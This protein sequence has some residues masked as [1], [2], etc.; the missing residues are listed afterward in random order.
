MI[1]RAKKSCAKARAQGGNRVFSYVPLVPAPT[2]P[3]RDDSL[4]ALVE[5]SLRSGGLQLMYQPIVAMR[6][7]AGRRY[8]ALLRLRAPDGE[9][10]P[11]FDFLPIAHARG[12]MPGIDCWVME[13]ALDRLRYERRQRQRGLRFFVHQTMESAASDG[14]VAWL[15]D[16]IAER[17]LIKVRPLIQFQVQDVMDHRDLA[18]ERARELHRL[19]IR[20]CLIQFEEN[21]DA[22]VLIEEMP[23]SMVKLSMET[24]KKASTGELTNLVAGLHAQKT[25]VIAPGI[26]GP[27]I[28][29]H[30]WGCG[31]DFI[32][33]NFLQF[34][35]EDLGFD[36]SESALR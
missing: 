22:L 27:S 31:V 36:F 35:A 9:Y 3:D 8:E 28:I 7:L 33:G 19:G 10:I 32:Q 15:R 4:T 18:L 24:I 5:W 2:A 13:H 34:P 1:S 17:D 20:I 12:L 14:W 26:D 23:V 6:N 29:A 11:T 21:H 16:Q 25:A 30:L